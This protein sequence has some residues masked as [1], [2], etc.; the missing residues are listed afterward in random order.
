[1]GGK[2]KTDTIRGLYK[3][4]KGKERADQTDTEKTS[5]RRQDSYSK[6]VV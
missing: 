2:E 5:K 4:R 3:Q 1:M 6:Q